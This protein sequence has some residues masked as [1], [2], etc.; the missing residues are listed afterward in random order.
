[1]HR[2]HNTTDKIKERSYADISGNN[3]FS[4]QPRRSAR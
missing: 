4:A 1:M 3:Y 2:V